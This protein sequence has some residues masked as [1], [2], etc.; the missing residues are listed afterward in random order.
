MSAPNVP[1]RRHAKPESDLHEETSLDVPSRTARGRQRREHKLD[2]QL[3]WLFVIAIIIIAL[4]LLS[5]T[6][7]G[8]ALVHRRL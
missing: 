7:W 8:L 5:K 1:T 4:Y 2:R 3:N 6:P